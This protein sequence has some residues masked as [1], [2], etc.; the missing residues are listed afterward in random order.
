MGIWISLKFFLIDL[1]ISVYGYISEQKCK[2]TFVR[3]KFM[4]ECFNRTKIEYD[5]RVH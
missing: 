3:N 1:L 5:I 2:K 4:N